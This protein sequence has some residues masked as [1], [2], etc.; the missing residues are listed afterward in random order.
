M[1]TAM[2][3]DTALNVFFTQVKE[4][5]SKKQTETNYLLKNS[6]VS[7]TIGSSLYSDFG[8]IGGSYA[9][10][11]K[12]T[13][14]PLLLYN[15]A[16]VNNSDITESDYFWFPYTSVFS[17]ADALN[18]DYSF[19]GVR[20]S[21]GLSTTPPEFLQHLNKKSENGDLSQK[22]YNCLEGICKPIKEHNTYPILYCDAIEVAVF[23]LLYVFLLEKEIIEDDTELKL[24]KEIKLKNSGTEVSFYDYFK[25]QQ[26]S[27]TTLWKKINKELQQEILIRLNVGCTHSLIDKFEELKKCIPTVQSL[28][29]KARFPVMPYVLMYWFE[30]KKNEKGSNPIFKP[31]HLVKPV[32]FSLKFQPEIKGYDNEDKV[33]FALLTVDENKFLLEDSNGSYSTE[34]RLF[35]RMINKLGNIVADTVFY[36]HFSNKEIKKQA[37]RAAISQV[38][39]RNTS[40]NIGAH[41]MNKLIGD[42]SS[43]ALLDFSKITELNYQSTYEKDLRK[44]HSDIETG[45][46]KDPDLSSLTNGQREKVLKHKILL[47]QIALFNNYVK[48]RMDYLADISFGTPL[49]QTNKYAYEDLFKELDKVRLLLEHISGLDRFKYEIQF[50]RN[51][52]RFKASKKPDITNDDGTPTEDLEATEDDLLVAIPNDI[53]G[54]QAFYNILEN[55]IRNTAKHSD[56]SKHDEK[57]PIVFTVNFI[58]E[59]SDKKNTDIEDILN[60]FIAVEVYDDI[61]VKET[62]TDETQKNEYKEKVGNE[63]INK[64]DWLVYSQNKKLNEDI[65]HENKLRSSSLGLVEMDASAAYLRKRDVGL[66]NDDK[67]NIEHNDSWRNNAAFKYYLKAFNKDNHLAYRFFLH[68]P[69]VVLVVTDANCTN[70]DKLKKEGIGVVTPDVFKKELEAGKVYP[71]EFV[72]YEK[73]EK[74]DETQTEEKIDIPQLIKDYK[75]SLPIRVLEVEK[76]KLTELFNK[77]EKPEEITCNGSIENKTKKVLDFW[78]EFCWTEWDTKTL[79]LTYDDNFCDYPLKGNLKSTNFN[80]TNK[81]PN[82]EVGDETQQNKNVITLNQYF[83]CDALS[84]GAQKKLPKCSDIDY[85]KTTVLRKDVVVRDKVGES[86]MS[87]ILV[88]DERIQENAKGKYINVP[89]TILYDK[90]GIIVPE[91]S[92]INLSATSM[93][94]FLVKKIK[95]LIR[96][97]AVTENQKTN[98]KDTLNPDFDFMLIHY[99]ILERMFNSDKDEIEK[100]LKCLGKY[101]NVVITSGRGEPDG[102]PREVRFINLS[103][104]IHA[105]VETRSKYFTNYILHQSRKSSKLKMKNNDKENFY[106]N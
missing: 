56:K 14:E 62:I 10:L 83:Y 25:E 1:S 60:G 32:W 54:T 96:K 58:D 7:G 87:R 15:T 72:V 79:K 43:L 12:G 93:S 92:Q 97:Y 84:S 5:I 38:M 8:L 89:L 40:H 73:Q 65:L 35:S 75:T 26:V 69:A 49:M 47:A 6:T 80:H 11:V 101:N 67:Y 34:F 48:C 77:V 21:Q 4:T 57:I 81:Y 59:N 99:S 86:I 88:I 94:P 9:V 20:S 28:H 3:I 53:L 23:C 33:I 91:Y 82:P 55:I 64:I 24:E 51:G 42:L 100:Y 29:Q 74:I 104:I 2:D 41:V 36:S 52:K 39:A 105:L 45:I 66:I 76:T 16:I 90:T 98:G 71:H 17:D 19:A 22:D 106:Y 70:K 37:T 103:S 31:A 63:L 85:Y 78:E 30:K 68:R 27:I 46:N 61:E 18:I 102:L 44:L 13:N 95:A 50:T